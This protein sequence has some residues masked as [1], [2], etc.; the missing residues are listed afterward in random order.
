MWICPECQRS[1]KTKNQWHSCVSIT[2]DF[3]FSEI[4]NSIKAVYD[5]LYEKCNTFGEIKTDTTLSCVYFTNLNRFLVLKP[6]KTGLIIEFVLDRSEDIFPVIK[7]VQ[8]SKNQFAH[9]LKLECKEDLNDQI[10]A[11]LKEAYELKN[12]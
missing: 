2:V 3:I 6:Q 7:T 9:R 11:W 10:F 8:I 12:K 5:I 1:F 4:P